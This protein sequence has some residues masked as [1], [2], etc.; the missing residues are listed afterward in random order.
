[1]RTSELDYPLPED[2]IALHP[3][4]PRDT[5]RLMVIDRQST[6]PEHAQVRDIPRWLR[7]GD[8]LVFNQSRVIP[9]R[10]EAVRCD[11]GG[12]VG[13]L[14]L[15]REGELWRAML[16]SRG[17]LEPGRSIELGGE[18]RLTLAESLGGGF[19][20][21]RPEVEIDPLQVLARHG[22]TPL[23]PYIRQARK[24][25]GLDP[26]SPIDQQ[27]YNTVYASQPGSIAAP[28]AGLHFT[29]Q[30][31]EELEARGILT[32]HITLHVGV[33]TF[34]PIRVD[35]LSEHRMHEEWFE[36]RPEARGK[37][38][39]ARREGRRI[40]PVG[41]TTVRTLESITPEEL[42][43]AEAGGHPIARPTSL[44]IQPGFRFQWTD[45]L[46]TNFHLPRSTLL[47]LVAALPGVGLDR[48]KQWYALAVDQR[49]RFFS[50]GDA[51]LIL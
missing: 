9:A 8:L 15:A 43:A 40:I 51:M 14:F 13:G 42:S 36:L 32:T 45:A 4:E 7:A 48:L 12:R 16:E 46:L 38:S 19:W 6:R 49:Y 20:R 22:S 28:T 2:R 34:L 18:L 26:V 25:A 1:M 17:R 3:A 35:D 41:T 27:C 21:V 37:I 23:P 50:Y 30:L 29:P 44:F 39:R 24:K 31:L 47:A 33:G 11:T 10:F 5:A